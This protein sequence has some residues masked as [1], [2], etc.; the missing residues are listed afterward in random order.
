MSPIATFRVEDGAVEAAAGTDAILTVVIYDEDD[1][2]PLFV[3]GQRG[4]GP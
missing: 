4:I 2:F 1:G 3:Q